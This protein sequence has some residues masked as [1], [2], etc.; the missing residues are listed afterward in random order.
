MSS[1]SFLVLSAIIVAACLAG[2]LRFAPKS[3]K[4]EPRTEESY[5]QPVA[6]ALVKRSPI[7]NSVT[8]SGSFRANQ[9]VD[10]HAKVAGYIQKIFVDVG[11]KVRAGQ[12]LAILEVPE[13]NAQVVGAKADIGRYQSAVHR[14]Q[15]DLQRAQSTHTA[16]HSAYTRLKE[17]SD[18]RSGLIAEQELDDSM[19]KDQETEAQIASAKAALSEAESQLASAHAN[20]DRLMA[21]EAYAHITAPFS[22]VITKRYADTGALIQAG[23]A[24]DTQSLPVVRL[25]EWTKLRLVVPIP[26]SAVPQIHLGSVVQVRVPSLAHTFDG[27]VARFADALDQKTRTMEAEIDVQNR[28]GAL[29]GGMY[30]ETDLVL[31][32]TNDALT[33]PIQAVDRTG[34]G[35]ASVLL[36]DREGTI[37]LRQIQLGEEGSDRVEVRSG[38]ADKDRVVIGNRT[39]FRPGEKVQPKLVDEKA[40]STEAGA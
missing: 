28:N 31:K 40:G 11:D 8:L 20:L 12:V 38:L 2:W 7:V 15:G 17:A 25:A 30:A 19:A 34:S 21:M 36:V 13:L 33:V 26:E 39:G 3:V 14:A 6:V 35:G 1:K 23:T 18:S 22:G 5:L 24:S 27:K 37:E 16:Y 29:V 9:E 10:V 32:Q 4:A